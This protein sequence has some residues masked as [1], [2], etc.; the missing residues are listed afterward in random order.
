VLPFDLESGSRFLLHLLSLDIATEVSTSE[1]KSASDLSERLSGHAVAIVQI[2]GLIHRRSWTIQEFLAIYDRNTRKMLGM[3]GHNSLDAVWKLS[4]ESL[5]DQ[6]AAFLGVLSYITPDSIPQALF[7]ASDPPNLPTS[8][9]FCTD[10]FMY[11]EASG[12]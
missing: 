4:F 3:S 8:L 5:N 2:A 10:E 1:A 7:E 11:V 12:V 9:Q 6:C